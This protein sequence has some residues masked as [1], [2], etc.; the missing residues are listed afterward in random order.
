MMRVLR[1]GF[2]G[3]SENY[4]G[5]EDALQAIVD[6]IEQKGG[7]VV[8]VSVLRSTRQSERYEAFIVVRDPLI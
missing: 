5:P 3:V 6:R 4:D 8:S 2:S 1:V 7:L